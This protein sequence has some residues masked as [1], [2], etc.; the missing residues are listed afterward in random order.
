MTT[1]IKPTV[2]SAFLREMAAMCQRRAASTDEDATFW[3]NVQNGEVCER[4]AA[5]VLQQEA[6]VA[7]MAEALNGGVAA[8]ADERRRQIE[9]EGWTPEH[10]NLHDDGELALAA[11]SYIQ[12]SFYRHPDHSDQPVPGNWPW[13]PSW[14]KPTDKR[15][16]LVKAGA[17]VAAEIDR[18]D[19]AAGT[20]PTTQ[21]GG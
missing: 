6:R 7:S 14:W 4:I 9:A 21:A 20:P 12:G 10:D 13:H 5:L 1:E 16:D 3:A 15:R 19:R 18:I 2:A 17:L 11:A 8:I